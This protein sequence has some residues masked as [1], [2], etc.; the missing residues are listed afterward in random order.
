M[1]KTFISL[2]AALAF[3]G[4]LSAQT[5]VS[6]IVSGV[7]GPEGNPYIAGSTLIVPHDSTLIILPGVEI[8]FRS[9]DSLKVS[10]QLTAIGTESDSIHFHWSGCDTCSTVGIH[11]I[12]SDTCRFTY[13][14][15]DTPGFAVKAF[16][17]PVIIERCRL[18]AMYRAVY[19]K[20]WSYVMVDQSNIWA[21]VEPIIVIDCCTAL[22]TNNVT[23]AYPYI[24]VPCGIYIEWGSYGEVLNNECTGGIGFSDSEGIVIGNKMSKLGIVWAS[25]PVTAENNVMPTDTGYISVTGSQDG[26]IRNNITH[27]ARA[28]GFLGVCNYLFEENEIYGEVEII[29]EFAHPIFRRNFIANGVDVWDDASVDLTNNTIHV[30]SKNIG[31]DANT[32]YG[33]GSLGDIRNNIILGYDIGGVGINGSGS[34]I[35]EYNCIWGFETPWID[36]GSATNNLLENPWLCGGNP[37]DY[38]LQANSPCID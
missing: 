14:A 35:V 32:Y 5:H 7:W 28:D 13:C 30:N 31:I 36:I 26:V 9:P 15:I 23:D 34:G 16:Q 17:S 8:Y 12:D 29:D 27:I 6:G 38:H 25:G 3:A 22:I 10:G 18:A 19:I 24:M 1:L 33:A 2:C 21:I 4:V 11:L 20:Y 37:F